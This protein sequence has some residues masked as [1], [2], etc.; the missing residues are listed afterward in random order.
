MTSKYDDLKVA[1]ITKEVHDD[2]CPC[3]KCGN[4]SAL[5]QGALSNVKVQREKV[6]VLIGTITRQLIK[7]PTSPNLNKDLKMLTTQLSHL[8]KVLTTFGK[9]KVGGKFL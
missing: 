1:K 4:Q 7:Y 2:T 5:R 8:E 9:R 3:D 6:L